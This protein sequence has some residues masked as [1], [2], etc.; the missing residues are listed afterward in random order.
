LVFW[1]GG[2]DTQ[3]TIAFGTPDAVYREVRERIAIF[4]E[5]GGYVFD[6]IHNIQGNTPIANVEAMFRAVRDSAG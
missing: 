1:G 5:G 4:N 3:Q 6:A 2:V